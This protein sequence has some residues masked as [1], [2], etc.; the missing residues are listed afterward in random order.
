MKIIHTADIHLGAK[1][2]SKFPKEISTKRKEE[3]RNTFRRMVEYACKNGV[4]AIMLAG[5]V[6]DSDNP[7]KKDKEFFYSVVRNNPQIEFFYLRGNHDVGADYASEAIQNLKTFTNEWTSYS[8]GNVV[9]SGLEIAAGNAASMYSTLAL[10]RENINIVMLHGQ[11][12]DSSGKDKINLKKLRDKNIDYLALGHIHKIQE[13]KL[14]DRAEY[15]YCGCLEGRGFD[16]CGEHG[17]MLLDVGEKITRKFV[18]FSERNI[19]ETDV[20]ITDVTEAYTAARRVKEAVS[21]NRRDIYRI[22]LIGEIAFDVD[23][24]RADVAKYLSAE[25]FYADVK[26]KTGKKL[27]YHKFDGDTSLKGEFVRCVYENPDF[28]DEEKKKIIGYGIRALSG[29]TI[30]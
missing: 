7:F 19:I 15:A 4:E 8:Y 17:F 5:D 1:M 16:E 30:E 24:L 12:A 11:I 9:I 6:F 26:D 22:N 25:C 2:D 13:G 3:L 29:G 21:F 20:D 23:D 28:T 18:P 27:D 10:N 14:D